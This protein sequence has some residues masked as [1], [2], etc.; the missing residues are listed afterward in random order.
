MEQQVL[1]PKY[2]IGQTIFSPR[3]KSE[4][5]KHDCPDCL[6]SQQWKTI[7]PAGTEHTVKCPRCQGGYWGDGLGDKI[8]S[9]DFTHYEPEVVEMQITGYC[10]NEYGS[11]K[12]KYSSAINGSSSYSFDEGDIITARETAEMIAKHK[13]LEANEKEAA[14]IEAI[15]ARVFSS[16]TIDDARLEVFRSQLWNA[17]YHLGNIMSELRD[18]LDANEG[19]SEEKL[20]E[21]ISDHVRW[22]TD[23]HFKHMPLA[24]LFKSVQ[25]MIEALDEKAVVLTE[26]FPD[27]DTPGEA[28]RAAW[29]GLPEE[30]RII[31][32][33]ELTEAAK[34]RIGY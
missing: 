19:T 23:Y 14:T 5:R 9:L 30:V 27:L 33:E 22:N 4:R 8:P 11:G 32:S 6:G 7:S 29:W 16:L 17:H 2:A 18:L 31:V 25:A 12:V 13:A 24:P 1:A 15:R 10:V 20:R 21:L 26:N 3:T 34:K 28:F